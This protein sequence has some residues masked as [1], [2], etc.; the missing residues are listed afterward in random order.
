MC[1]LK[2]WLGITEVLT[3]WFN[4]GKGADWVE[5]TAEGHG[6]DGFHGLMLWTA[7]GLNREHGLLIC[8]FAWPR[9]GFCL[10][11]YMAEAMRRGSKYLHGRRRRNAA[12]IGFQKGAAGRAGLIRSRSSLQW[13]DRKRDV[14]EDVELLQ[15]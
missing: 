12:R 5:N 9:L 1:S 13:T 6:S 11:L 2:F 4:F 15:N 8:R 14:M 7:R 10:G 3:G